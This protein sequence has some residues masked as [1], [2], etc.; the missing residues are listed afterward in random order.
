[1][2]PPSVNMYICHCLFYADPAVT[3][4]YLFYVHNCTKCIVTCYVLHVSWPACIYRLLVLPF[5]GLTVPYIFLML[6]WCPSFLWQQSPFV[7]MAS[8]VHH[9]LYPPVPCHH[10]QHLITEH[11][12]TRALGSFC[13]HTVCLTDLVPPILSFFTLHTP[14]ISSVPYWLLRSLWH[15]SMLGPSF[16][17]SHD[18]P[19]FCPP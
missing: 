3:V 2:F 12:C 1:M 15:G 4:E 10:T 19:A 5:H 16:Y 9:F 7:F 17:T 13:G 6:F 8:T 11:A 14:L 18:S